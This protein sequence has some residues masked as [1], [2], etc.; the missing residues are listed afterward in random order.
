MACWLQVAVLCAIFL[1]FFIALFPA[2]QA[3]HW[4]VLHGTPGPD[5]ANEK[6][7]DADLMAQ[8]KEFV[9]IKDKWVSAQMTPVRDEYDPK[10]EVALNDRSQD[11]D[12]MVTGEMLP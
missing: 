5:F 3:D 8:A 4:P 11:C 1:L 10:Q 9:E 2:F 6:F 7:G 12:E